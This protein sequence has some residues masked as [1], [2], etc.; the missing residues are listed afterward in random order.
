MAVAEYF[1]GRRLRDMIG[2]MA[3]T[4]DALPEEEYTFGTSFDYSVWGAGTVIHLANVP[5]DNTYRDVVYYPSDEAAMAAIIDDG[6]STTITG[7]TYC[8]QGRPIRISL[9]FSEANKYNYVVVNNP[10]MPVSG[11]SSRN[12][13]YY[14][15]VSVE[16]TAPNTTT[17]I[18]QLDVWQTYCREV[19]FGKSYVER[20]HLGI[21]AA[22]AFDKNGA[23]YLSVPEGMDLGSHYQVHG[24]YARNLNSGGVVI[25][26][27]VML[28]GKYGDV[29]NPHFTMAMGSRAAGLPHGCA[30]Y[31]AS[32]F[33][34]N[35]LRN[36][37]GKYPWVSQG[38]ISVT[39]IPDWSIR[40][41]GLAELPNHEEVY[42][43][44]PDGINSVDDFDVLANFRN[45][46]R[47]AVS[48][49]GGNSFVANSS[50]ITGR[51]RR[52]LKFLTAPY[53]HV[54]LTTFSGTPIVINPEMLSSDDITV[55][56][57]S[58]VTPPGPRIMFTVHNLNTVRPTYDGTD[59]SHQGEYFDEM[60]GIVNLPT[61]SLT[62]NSYGLFMAS[63]ANSLAYQHYSADWSQQKATMGASTSRDV[64]YNVASATYTQAQNQRTLNTNK[65]DTSN[66]YSMR[67]SIVNAMMGIASSGLSGD[68][69]GMLGSAVSG[70]NGG[71]Q[72]HMSNQM[73]TS[74][75]NMANN[76][77][78]IG[79]NIDAG[80][81]RATAD[82]NYA[83]ANYAAQGD[84]ASAIAGIQAKVRD[85]R[86]IP[87]SVVGQI[88][89]DGFLLGT[90]GWAVYVRVR[91]IGFEAMRS[92]GE[93]W[94]RYGYAMNVFYTIPRNF[95][96]MSRFTYWKCAETTIFSSTCPE[97]FRQTIRGIFE[98]GVT[99]WADKNDI[100]RID[101]ADNAP[102]G[103]V[104]L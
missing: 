6:P 101:Y 89:G 63:N 57:F 80:T 10:A 37:L 56:M 102:I 59:N 29:S 2:F 60:T 46:I 68:A 15:I 54:E 86:L 35:R 17:L 25:V 50:S 62:N 48:T 22:N 87:P 70:L 103:G 53:S 64:A 4:I 44:G 18:V 72:S 74:M 76:T 73:N 78:R 90:V 27:T 31:Y 100:G 39:A 79:S 13:F 66:D 28:D 14:F 36:T 9:P 1:G 95:Q 32:S 47:G 49:I 81:Q 33:G 43:I 98:K 77:A 84:Y 104:T 93:F 94:L 96:V 88:G 82:T 34:Y 5:W 55:T 42:E 52:L 92:I 45:Y 61:F 21:A 67:S 12:V 40:M 75:T 41:S 38:I 91:T 69:M 58:H 8:A 65:T 97:V 26:S 24:S 20:G 19:R 83:Y 85:A 7:L 3:D 30:I 11:G 99:V 16:Y 23:R 71:L 51:Y